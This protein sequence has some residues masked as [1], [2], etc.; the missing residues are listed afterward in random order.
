MI[1]LDDSPQ[2]LKPAREMGITTVLV[3]SPIMALKDLKELTGI[4]VSLSISLL[5]MTLERFTFALTVLLLSVSKLFYHNS[6]SLS[7]TVKVIY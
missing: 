7:L 6:L 4:D 3:K 5:L 2:N 1:F